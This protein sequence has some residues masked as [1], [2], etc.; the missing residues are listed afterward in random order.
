V[1][2]RCETPTLAAFALTV[3]ELNQESTGVKFDAGIIVFADSGPPLQ[4]TPLRI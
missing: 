3:S 4:T 2:V 1:G